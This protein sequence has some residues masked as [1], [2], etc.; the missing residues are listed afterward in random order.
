MKIVSIEMLGVHPGWRKN[1]NFVRIQTDAGIVGWGE[2]YS[3]YDRDQPILAMGQEISRYLIGRD[4]FRIRHARQI[5]MDDFSQRRPSLELFCAWS[6]IEAALWD[7]VGKATDQP[8]YNL[9]GGQVRS[10]I[11]VYANGWSYKLATPDDFVRAAEKVVEAGYTALKFDPLPRPWRSY[12]PKEHIR[13]AVAVVSALRKALGP[14]IDLLID[15]HRR[16]APMHAI[17]LINSL[18][19]FKPYWFEEPCPVAHRDALETI[20]HASPIPTVTGEAVYGLEGFSPII[21]NRSVDIINPDVAN[22]GG[23]LELLNI[24]AAAEAQMI[25]VSPHNY[26]STTLALAATVHASACMPNFVITEYFLPF[27]ELGK[28]ICRNPFVPKNGYL[29]LPEG[30]GLG[31]DI[32]EAALRERASRPFPA[33]TLRQAED[34][35]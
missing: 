33:R 12:I 9:L 17:E 3:Q 13:H 15:N 16:L 25:A 22:C 21:A 8:V 31:M 7:I 34:E 32:D 1:L 24:A 29:T 11:K 4:P 10:R 19:E 20:T 27:E 6:G 2:A 14:D 18:Q 28:Q 5:I 23:I 30:P 35:M 26:N